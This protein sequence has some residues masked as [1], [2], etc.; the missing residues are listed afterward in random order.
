MRSSY[1][2]ILRLPEE[3]VPPIS[4]LGIP[5]FPKCFYAYVDSAMSS[6][7]YRFGHH[8]ENKKRPHWH[9]D[10][11]NDKAEIIDILILETTQKA[12]CLLCQ[13][14][15]REFKVITIFSSSDCKGSSHLFFG[16]NKQKAKNRSRGSDSH[17]G[18]HTNIFGI[19]Y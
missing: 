17:A 8:L 12:K 13:A 4:K 3:Q 19:R 7:E 10:Y 18:Q 15:A 6:L 14:L 11:L 1:S 16:N 2:R 9:I 5:T